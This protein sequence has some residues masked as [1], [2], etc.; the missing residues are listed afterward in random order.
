MN[1]SKVSLGK[2]MRGWIFSRKGIAGWKSAVKLHGE[3]VFARL[4]IN[5]VV[6]KY[7]EY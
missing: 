6:I 7:C 3:P 1:I 2:E 4:S 5:R